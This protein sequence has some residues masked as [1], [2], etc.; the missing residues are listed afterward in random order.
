MTKAEDLMNKRDKE[1]QLA[2]ICLKFND[3]SGAKMHANAAEGF[4][5]KLLKMTVKEAREQV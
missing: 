2:I 3:Y 4:N 1:T 5:T